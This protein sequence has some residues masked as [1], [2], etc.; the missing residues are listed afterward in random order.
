[1]AQCSCGANSQAPIK[2]GGGMI[3]V[4]VQGA[5]EIINAGHVKVFEYCRSQGDKLIVGLNTNTLLQVY[6][7]RQAVFPYE[8]KKLVIEAIR[9]VDEVF[10]ANSFSPMEL[11]KA[12]D[13]DVY[14]VAREWED[15]KAEEIAWMLSNGK[16]IKLIP[17]FGLTR[18]SQVKERLL[19]ESLAKL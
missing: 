11:L 17:D 6:K 4:F 9:F 12:L 18:T 5:F 10:P 3:K 13:I 7:K 15:T 16:Q 1:M 14:C 19:A 2:R 8:E